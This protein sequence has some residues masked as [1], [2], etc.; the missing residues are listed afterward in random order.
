MHIARR[1]LGIEADQLHQV[2]NLLPALRLRLVQ[3][4]NVQRLPD[5]IL[6]RHAG[7]Q[8]GVRVLKH[9]L[10]LTAVVVHVLL[11]DL[12][13]VEADG[14]AGRLVEMQQRPADRR[15]AAAGLAHEAQR[16]ARTDPEADA[17]HG[18]QHRGLAEA[19]VNREVFLQVLDLDEILARSFF[20]VAHRS[21]TSI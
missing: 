16:L 8:R 11:R 4:M 19:G 20:Y 5:D 3:M 17:V 6:H 9:H 12:R 13:A 15:L 2:Q 10:H 18:L 14:S 7:V 1:V 21:G